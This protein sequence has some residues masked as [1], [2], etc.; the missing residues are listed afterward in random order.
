MGF[1]SGWLGCFGFLIGMASCFTVLS[2]AGPFVRV[3]WLAF[4]GA[5]LVNLVV[6]PF[7]PCS[8]GRD[9]ESFGWALLGNI[10]VAWRRRLG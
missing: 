6:Q 1:Q 10:A 4:G 3:S 2:V 7:A 9:F 5:I 8:F